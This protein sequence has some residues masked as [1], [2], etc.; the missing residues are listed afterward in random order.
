MRA[1]VDLELPPESS[2]SES[3]SSDSS[4]SKSLDESSTSPSS[5]GFSLSKGGMPSRRASFHTWELL[6]DAAIDARADE[7]ERRAVPSSLLSLAARAAWTRAGAAAGT[8]AGASSSSRSSSASR[9]SGGAGT[10]ASA[11]ATAARS[12]AARYSSPAAVIQ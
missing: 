8:G 2:S 11:S 12:T 6:V 1:W 4:L 7:A 3:S 9:R 10:G 5:K